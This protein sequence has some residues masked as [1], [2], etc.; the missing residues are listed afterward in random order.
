MCELVPQNRAATFRLV[1]F[2]SGITP[3][4]ICSAV[5]AYGRIMSSFATI[6]ADLLRRAMLEDLI[7]LKRLVPVIAMMATV[8]GAIVIFRYGVHPRTESIQASEQRNSN[9]TI[10]AVAVIIGTGVFS[11]GSMVIIDNMIRRESH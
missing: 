10:I 3:S 8:C 11:I 1:A 6:Q 7:R 9:Q 4:Y 5:Q 2:V